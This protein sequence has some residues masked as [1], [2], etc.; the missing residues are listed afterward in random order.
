MSSSITVTTA[1][2]AESLWIIR[3]RMKFMGDVPGTGLAVG[4][5][6]VPPGS[7][8]PPH[9]HASPEVFRVLSGE[10][11]FGVFGEKPPRLVV[12]GAG[13]VVSVPPHAPHNYHNAGRTPATMLV[14][15]V[16]DMITFFRDLGRR[17]EPPAGPPSAAELAGVMA[18]C[19][20]HHITLLSGPPA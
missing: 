7:G 12:A 6:E 13:A 1:A 14:V 17:E 9:T 3:D 20:R 19:Q 4:E 16:Q 18:A 8:T 11:T 5:L 10:V 15:V 2:N